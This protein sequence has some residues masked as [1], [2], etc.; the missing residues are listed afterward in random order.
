MSSFFVCFI[1]GFWD[2]KLNA[3]GR[4][5]GAGGISL[6]LDHD[7]LKS[8]WMLMQ[9]LRSRLK[10]ERIMGMGKRKEEIGNRK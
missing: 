9:L 1:T 6:E 2:D 10:S 5:G 8:W 4:A 7:F 3:A